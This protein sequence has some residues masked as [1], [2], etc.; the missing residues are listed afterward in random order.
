M[1]SEKLTHYYGKYND[2]YFITLKYSPFA[3]VTPSYKAGNCFFQVFYERVYK[4][5][6]FVPY[7]TYLFYWQRGDVYYHWVNDA[8]L[9]G[10]ISDEQLAELFQQELLRL[11]AYELHPFHD[12]IQWENGTYV[13]ASNYYEVEKKNPSFI[14]NMHALKEVECVINKEREAEITFLVSATYL[15]CLK[16]LPYGV[17]NVEFG[18]ADSQNNSLSS[19][20]FDAKNPI[21]IH[22][23]FAI[24]SAIE[25]ERDGSIK[26][27]EFYYNWPI[28]VKDSALSAKNNDWIRFYIYLE[29]ENGYKETHYGEKLYYSVKKY[30]YNAET[31]NYYNEYTFSEKFTPQEKY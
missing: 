8:H 12:A 16:S 1:G 7:Y 27:V 15:D 31:N 13:T 6:Y 20:T 25:H 4:E 19:E 28:L 23:L 24:P 11:R 26:S 21:E 10:I 3:A 18:I 14:I 17:K 9:S 2:C 5:E 29:Y 22:G 30:Q